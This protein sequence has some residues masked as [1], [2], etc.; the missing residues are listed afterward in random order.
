KKISQNDIDYITDQYFSL[1]SKSH[2]TLEHA[3]DI[4]FDSVGSSCNYYFSL[5]KQLPLISTDKSGLSIAYIPTCHFKE[6]L[7]QNSN[8]ESIMILDENYKIVGHSEYDSIGENLSDK[9]LIDTL[10]S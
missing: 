6:I 1:P 3:S 2:W 5:V 7:Q 9:R 10:K 8:S 4:L